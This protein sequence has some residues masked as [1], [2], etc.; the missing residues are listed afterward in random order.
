M[1]ATAHGSHMAREWLTR[2]VVDAWRGT[3]CRKKVKLVPTVS[4]S[5]ATEQEFPRI[6][7]CCY[8]E[9]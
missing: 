5:A 1:N 2:I 9:C 7:R 3:P 8:M 6:D 4:L